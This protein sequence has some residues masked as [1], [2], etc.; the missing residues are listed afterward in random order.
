M[1][2]VYLRVF[3]ESYN[4]TNTNNLY[5]TCE[6]QQFDNFDLWSRYNL[7]SVI[8]KYIVEDDRLDIDEDY[9]ILCPLY[10]NITLDWVSDFQVGV[11]ET[12]HIC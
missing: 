11:T 5:Y 7:Q 1:S 4:P 12:F 6:Y 10:G 2:H 3:D 8:L 9:Y